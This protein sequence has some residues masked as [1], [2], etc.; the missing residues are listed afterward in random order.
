[1]SKHAILGVTLLTL[2]IVTAIATVVPADAAE[3]SGGA[4]PVSGADW[5]DAAH[6]PGRRYPPRAL[7]AKIV[8]W[9][10]ANFE[11]AANDD[12]PNVE[13]VP[14]V[15]LVSMRY[16]GLLSDRWREG[17]NTAAQPTQPSDIVAVYNDRSRTIYLSEAWAGASVKEQSILVH[18][19]VHHL[20]NLHGMKYECAGAREELA[21]RAQ[22][23]WLAQHNLDLERE[24]EIDKFTILV[25]SSCMF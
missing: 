23:E 11:I 18:E 4:A 9:L 8:T 14:A 25:K 12:Y 6:Q 19:M 17:S 21:Y 2:A 20:Q 5:R 15:R 16:N 7:L 24:F 3:N 13:F 1:M 10:S 22:G